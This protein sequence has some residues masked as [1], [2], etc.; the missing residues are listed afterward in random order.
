M[1]GKTWVF[2]SLVAAI[3]LVTTAAAPA[4]ADDRRWGM[5]RPQ[6]QP[7]AH[8]GWFDNNRGWDRNRS[9]ERNG[10]WDRNR[11][12]DRDRDWRGNRDWG[13]ERE[14]WSRRNNDHHWRG[15]NDR[16]EHD[17][18]RHHGWWRHHRQR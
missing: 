14:A 18:G 7:P 1:F 13:R 17:R 3:T 4:Q 5:G 2:G 9:S 10:S 12:G 8:A 15:R 11:S 16:W 6:W